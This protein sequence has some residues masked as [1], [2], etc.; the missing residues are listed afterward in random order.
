MLKKWIEKKERRIIDEDVRSD[1]VRREDVTL[2]YKY[3]LRRMPES[4]EVIQ[5]HINNAATVESLVDGFIASEEFQRRYKNDFKK[6]DTDIT[7]IEIYEKAKSVMPFVSVADAHGYRWLFNSKDTVISDG[8]FWNQGK[9][10]QKDDIDL[11]FFLSEKY[12]YRNGLEDGIFLDIGGNIGTTSIPIKKERRFVT[13]VIAFEP[14]ADNCRVFSANCA[15]NDL[16]IGKDIVLENIGISNV[17]GMS[18]L[19]LSENNMGD[20]R[21]CLDPNKAK[22]EGNYEQ[23]ELKTLEKYFSGQQ[24]PFEEVKYIWVD[25]QGHEG[26]VLDGAKEL[27]LTGNIPLLIEFWPDEM[28]RV[29]GLDLLLSTLKETYADFI[30]IGRYRSGE[31]ARPIEE[32]SSLAS[33]YTDFTFTDIF[34]IK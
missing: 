10:H 2:A 24:M 8:M 28:R 29:G 33:E 13:K 11:F 3:L 18:E 7:A 6:K 17:N 15:I 22:K 27:L 20:H 21:V 1:K 14:S 32:L 23:I 25:T 30:D 19:I 5:Y 31:G 26:F 12:Y 34:L 4:E 16:D 9:S